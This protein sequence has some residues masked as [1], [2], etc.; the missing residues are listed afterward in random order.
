VVEWRDDVQ[1]RKMTPKEAT[2]KAVEAMVV[3]NDFIH[4]ETQGDVVVG[5]REI[6]TALVHVF[7][8]PE[9]NVSIAV[10]VASSDGAEAEKLRAA[11]CAHVFDGPYD[12]RIP[13][14]LDS[15]T[16]GRKAAGPVIEYG[17][18][19][20]EEDQLSFHLTARAALARQG[21]NPSTYDD[22]SCVASKGG[23]FVNVYSLPWNVPAEKRTT[24]VL[25]GAT[26]DKEARALRDGILGDVKSG[27]KPRAAATRDL[28]DFHVQVASTLVIPKGNDTIDE[29]HVWHALP[30]V[31]P[32]SRMTGQAGAAAITWSAGGEQQYDKG[33]ESHHVFWSETGKMPPGSTHR[34]T[35]AFTVRSA[36]R[37]FDP[38]VA[39]VEW[40]DYRL[41][42]RSPMPKVDPEQAKKVPEKIAALA[43]TLKG[44]AG[45]AQA[46]VAF[47]KWI[48]AN[49][50]Y[51][52]SVPWGPGDVVST[53]ENRRGH[54]GHE[55]V[56]LQNM[57]LHCG[58]PIRA[59]FGLLLYAPDGK[60]GLDAVRADYT[61]RHTW[62][63]VYLPGYGWVE[64]E[65]TGGEGA[66][67]IPNNYVQNNKWFQ[68]YAVWI[69]E[70]GD[71]KFVDGGSGYG[72]AN[73]I[74]YSTGRPEDA[75]NL[76]VNGTFEVGPALDN[77]GV[78]LNPGSTALQG[79]TATRGQIDV[80]TGKSWKAADGDRS[81]DL[82]G[83]PGFGGI[84]QTFETKKGQR[85]RVTFWMAGNP[86]G[87]VPVKNLAVAAA[88][89]SQAFAFDTT[90]RTADR[91]GAAGVGVRGRGRPDH[92]GVLHHDEDRRR[93]RPGP[94]QRPGRA[95]AQL[96]VTAGLLRRLVRC[97]GGDSTPMVRSIRLPR[98]RRRVE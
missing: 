52:P 33:Q 50:T 41:A 20:R 76:L 88:G 13:A 22:W 91:M 40:N 58:I 24:L 37:E 47:C 36:G 71:W 26:S 6:A 81:L 67:R 19:T 80:V 89:K 10:L 31:R 95:R 59:V 23:A 30:T 25:V 94:R 93:R 61:N 57:C 60:S 83:S 86:V 62:A 9:G 46:V 8:L 54:C 35:S 98:R 64:V 92:P 51:D 73:V 68:N 18:N 66:F 97:E 63:E 75:T 21:L 53:F 44:S 32:W 3:K 28:L 82:H 17:L 69:R 16:T 78:P 72:V 5:R 85:Y 27:L 34:F 12:P 70:K 2:T 14:R 1:I 45:P 38:A 87:E 43:D 65:P 48:G 15:K 39:R 96:E 56:L 49:V 79:W 7:P 55:F 29:I 77:W 74:T 90:G 4:A 11:L 84:A 42:T